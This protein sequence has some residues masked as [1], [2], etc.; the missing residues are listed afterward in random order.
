QMLRRNTVY[1][2]AE[3]QASVYRCKFAASG[4]A[5]VGRVGCVSKSG[6]AVSF[7]FTSASNSGFVLKRFAT[8]CNVRLKARL[9]LKNYWMVA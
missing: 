9:L 8:V 7:A 2:V 5:V 6:Q 3:S 1:V 4:T